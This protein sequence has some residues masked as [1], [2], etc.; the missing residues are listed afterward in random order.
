MKKFSWDAYVAP[1]PQVPENVK[2]MFMEKL[3]KRDME[4]G[5]YKEVDVTSDSGSDTL[6]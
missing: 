2:N 6:K 1:C 3:Q 4:D 5:I